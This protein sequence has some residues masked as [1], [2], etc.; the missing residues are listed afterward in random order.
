V[1]GKGG[2]GTVLRCVKKSTRREYAIKIV[3]KKLLFDEYNDDPTRVTDEVRVLATL[4]HPF[5]V[6][7][8]Y[9]FQTSVYGVMALEYVPGFIITTKK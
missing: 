6:G 2:Y 7:M 4:K 8:D 1:L 3:N 9:S 5:I